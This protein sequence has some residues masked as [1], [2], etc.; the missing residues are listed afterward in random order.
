MSLEG[1]LA[2]MTIPKGKSDAATAR[3]ALE[4]NEKELDSFTRTHFYGSWCMSQMGLT[5]ATF[6]P[7]C[8]YQN[9]CLMNIAMTHVLRA[10][11]LTEEVLGY[12]LHEHFEE[13][14]A[15]KMALLGPGS[16]SPAGQSELKGLLKKLF[17]RRRE[18]TSGQPGISH[19]DERM[20]HP[21]LRV[22][23][24]KYSEGSQEKTLV[25]RFL[26]AQC[27][28]EGFT[29]E[30]NYFDDDS[31]LEMWVRDARS[32]A[33]EILHVEPQTCD[34]MFE[35]DTEESI[36]SVRELFLRELGAQ[37]SEVSDADVTAALVQWAK[38][39]E[40]GMAENRTQVWELII[41]VVDAALWLGWIFP[42]S[43]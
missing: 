15:R 39:R 14:F 17:G 29:G 42:R 36:Q 3:Q 9:G 25:L 24:L 8:I 26:Q 7:N 5:Y 30:E 22:A 40:V 12:N 10:Q 13:A 16:R 31:A 41:D 2:L 19:R 34:A 33:E 27:A 4:F 18:E 23:G 43:K 28:T 6:Y 21:L 35:E 32:W 38:R 37:P 20:T 1:L 11:W